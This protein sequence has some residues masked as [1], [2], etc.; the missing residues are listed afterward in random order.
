[1]NIFLKLSLLIVSESH[2]ECVFTGFV[3]FGVILVVK[4]FYVLFYFEP[5]LLVKQNGWTIDAHMKRNI[6]TRAGLKIE[7]FFNNL[8]R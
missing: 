8:V 2:V 7:D 1:M 4:V 5:K 3:N 6:R